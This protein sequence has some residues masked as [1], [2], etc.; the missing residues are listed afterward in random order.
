MPKI[1]QASQRAV[2]RSCPT[3]RVR[4]AHAA[5]IRSR[6]TREA[7]DL[8]ELGEGE[9]LASHLRKAGARAQ[10][11]NARHAR[12]PG[13]P[14]SRPRQ[15]RCE[16]AAGGGGACMVRPWK[17]CLTV[18]ANRLGLSDSIAAACPVASKC[19]GAASE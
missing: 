14:R 1:A 6:N 9:S 15:T 5:L 10:H 2:Q 19:A 13:T 7:S 17:V 12:E 18:S 8:L 3:A 16:A 11:S 4:L